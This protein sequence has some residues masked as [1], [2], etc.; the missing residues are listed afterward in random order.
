M[1]ANGKNKRN[2][3][4]AYHI[5]LW[6][7][8][9]VWHGISLGVSISKN[10]VMHNALFHL[11]KFMVT[12]S[13]GSD[14]SSRIIDSETKSF[15][16]DH[17]E[18][19]FSNMAPTFKAPLYSVLHSASIRTSKSESVNRKLFSFGSSFCSVLLLLLLLSCVSV[20][21]NCQKDR[22]VYR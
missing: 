9:A 18:Q 1:H 7:L 11:L 5:L 13:K 16:E 2:Q 17:S 20:D 8:V 3:F 12:F 22:Y 10:P 14:T 15:N 19:Y 21:M 4:H 6:S